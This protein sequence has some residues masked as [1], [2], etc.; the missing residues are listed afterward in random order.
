[1]ECTARFAHGRNAEEILRNN[2]VLESALCALRHITGGYSDAESA[3]REIGSMLL[4]PANGSERGLSVIVSLLQRPIEHTLGWSVLKALLG[5]IG[6]LA[7]E[8]ENRV[9]A[10][11]T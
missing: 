7:L 11:R 8:K 2:E 10:F 4:S 6:N 1:M 5:L 3:Q 9:V